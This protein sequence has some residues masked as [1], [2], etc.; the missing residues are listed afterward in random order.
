MTSLADALALR[1]KTS[2]GLKRRLT[3]IGVSDRLRARPALPAGR[4]AHIM[5]TAPCQ[6]DPRCIA[7]SRIAVDAT[8]L[9]MNVPEYL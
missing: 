9:K 3:P 6:V 7:A 1:P 4:Q 2:T 5:Q 8:T